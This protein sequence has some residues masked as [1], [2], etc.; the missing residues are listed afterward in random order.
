MTVLVGLVM[1]VI[2]SMC[3]KNEEYCEL[4]SL[5]WTE[6]N[7]KLLIVLPYRKQVRQEKRM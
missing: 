4:L 7:C 2:A 3:R 5:G 1:G 6:T